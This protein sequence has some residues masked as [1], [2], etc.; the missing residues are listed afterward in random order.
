MIAVATIDDVARLASALP[1]VVDGERHGTRAWFVRGKV[2]AWVRPFSKADIRRYGDQ[3]PPD[4]DIIAINTAGLAEKEAIL[5]S[6]DAFFTIP[7]FN[8]YAAILVRLNRIDDKALGEAIVD[9]WL[10]CAPTE[11]AAAYVNR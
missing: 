10:A 9:G 7:H 2:F 6:H 3:T 1:E 8:G 11:L 4:G 5:A